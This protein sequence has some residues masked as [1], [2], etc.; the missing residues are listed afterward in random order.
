MPTGSII[1]V[2]Y[3]NHFALFTPSEYT[4]ILLTLSAEASRKILDKTWRLR[5]ELEQEP[6]LARGP[7][8]S[9]TRVILQRVSPYFARPLT[10]LKLCQS[11]AQC[12]RTDSP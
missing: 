9:S 8:D 6:R 12:G 5:R 11:V 7:L 3:C 10:L 2:Y 1:I 4:E